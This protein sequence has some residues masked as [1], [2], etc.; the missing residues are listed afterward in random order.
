MR[1][2]LDINVLLI[3]LSIKSR[4]RPIFNALRKG[5]FEMVVSTDI[6]LEYHEK[7]SEKASAEVADNV[8]K[9]ILSL[10]NCLLQSTFFEWGLMHNDEDDNKYVNCAIVANADHLVS[11]DRHF[12]ILRDIDFPKLSVIKVD[13]FLQ[14]LNTPEP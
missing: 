4:Y 9:F 13:E 7:I 3:S 12:K 1:I 5:D 11:E 14:M 8:L 6:L 2:V 10:E